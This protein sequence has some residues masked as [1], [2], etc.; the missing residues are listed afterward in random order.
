MSLMTSTNTAWS[1]RPPIKRVYQI[2][3]GKLF[4]PLRRSLVSNQII[5]IDRDAGIVLDVKSALEVEDSEIELGQN[6]EITKID[7]SHLV[8]LPGLV[9]VHV[10]CESSF[11]SQVPRAPH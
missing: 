6:V 10:H 11:Y 3:A 9:D 2:H 7:L 4:D 8:V 5:T 1:S